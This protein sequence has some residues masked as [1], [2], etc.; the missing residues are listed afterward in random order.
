MQNHL[1]KVALVKDDLKI[2]QISQERTFDEVL[3]WLSCS[4]QLYWKITP[5]LSYSSWPYSGW[6][7][8][9]LLTDGGEQKCPLSK[10]C[11][12]YPTMMKL[13]T[14]IPY[15]KKIQKIYE[16]S[17]QSCWHHHVF[18]G[19]QQ[20]RIGDKELNFSVIEFISK[21]LHSQKQWTSKTS[22]MLLFSRNVM[23]TS[24][25]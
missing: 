5:S 13:G 12:T 25:T 10:I 21:Q 2:S 11:H 24:R 19:K 18:T 9:G 22:N 17:L 14:F 6:A 8:S 4:L 23:I 3:S 15:L 7:F 1:P 20:H 16:S